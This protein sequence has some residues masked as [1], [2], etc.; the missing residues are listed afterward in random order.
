MQ[1]KARPGNWTGFFVLEVWGGKSDATCDITYDVTCR[2][3]WL[4][5]P[6]E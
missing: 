3:E 1:P 5:G 6:S 4:L 2:A